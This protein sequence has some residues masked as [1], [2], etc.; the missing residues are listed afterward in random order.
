M[1]AD[2]GETALAGETLRWIARRCDV[3][4]LE[5]YLAHP[6]AMP[7]LA[8]PW[9]LEKSV[10]GEADTEF[11]TG[12]MTSSAHG[13]FFIRMLDDLMD[14]HEVDRA[15]LPALHLFSF[16]FQ[17]IYSRYF[18]ARDP[19]WEYFERSLA[20]TA[21][22]VSADFGLRQISS[23]DFLTITARKSSAALIPIAAVCS[24]YCRFDLL[25]KWEEFL[26]LFSRWHQM[27]DDIVD[28][29][30]DYEGGHSTWILTE[31]QAGKAPG[32][33]V[34]VWMGRTGLAWAYDV[35]AGWMREIRAAAGGLSS[36]ELIG[37]LDA[38]EATFARQMN[39]K[40]QLAALCESLLK[41]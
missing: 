17:S 6:E 36:S 28:W 7:L 30:E 10:R 33:T 3:A 1:V 26:T 9:W 39:A 29:S 18:P 20:S 32:E 12:L 22:A 14:G 31:A 25:P 37:Y 13:Y 40:I 34:P 2:I 11:Q 5:R 16:H 35:M 27:R 23:Q 41:A 4:H 38:R 15:C 21:E 19:F 24:R 8:L